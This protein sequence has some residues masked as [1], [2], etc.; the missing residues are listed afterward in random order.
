MARKRELK[1]GVSAYAN[2]K[3]RCDVCRAAN[4]EYRRARAGEQS[5]HTSYRAERDR[6]R[7]LAAHLETELA[8]AQDTIERLVTEQV[9]LLDGAGQCIDWAAMA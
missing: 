3:C 5:G 8:L 1:H 6:A 9:R 7:D 2:G 4:T